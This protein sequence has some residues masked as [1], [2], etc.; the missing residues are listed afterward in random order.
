MIQS[1]VLPHAFPMLTTVAQ[2]ALAALLFLSVN[3]VGKQ[4]ISVGYYQISRF[5]DVEDAPAFNTLFRILAPLVFLIVTATA[6]YALGLRRVLDR[7]YLVVVFYFG[8]R[9]TFNVIMGRS[10]LVRWDRQLAIG[11]VTSGCAYLAY[12]T[13]IRNPSALLPTPTELGN[14]LW[15]AI[16]L[17]VYGVWD[18]VEARRPASARKRKEYIGNRYRAYRTKFGRIIVNEAG[19]QAV[20]AISYAVLIY[21]TFNRPAFVQWLERWLF[22][23]LGLSHSLGPMQVRT[24]NRVS[25]EESV[26]LGVRKISSDFA[27]TVSARVVKSR[28]TGAVVTAV[29]SDAGESHDAMLSNDESIAEFLKLAFYYRRSVVQDTAA[30]YN[31]RSDYGGEVSRIYELVVTDFYPKLE[32]KV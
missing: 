13:L 31:V 12:R 7:Y 9:W 16:I 21:E 3:W 23:T 17:F 6:F 25:N 29:D 11:V 22:F 10:L 2:L 30:R 18:R 26:R 4:S 14:Q 27:A 20:E 1:R 28:G 15:L 32:P 8:I 5:A 24:E 19:N